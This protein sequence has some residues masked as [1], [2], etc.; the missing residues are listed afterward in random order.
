ML[1]QV[2]IDR[3]TSARAREVRVRIELSDIILIDVNRNAQIDN[4]RIYNRSDGSLPGISASS[5]NDVMICCFHI[6]RA[7]RNTDIAVPL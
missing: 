2:R 6:R 1:R 7:K 4:D 5:V 3:E